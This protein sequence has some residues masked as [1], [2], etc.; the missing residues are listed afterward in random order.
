MLVSR[1]VGGALLAGSALGLTVLVPQSALATSPA[2]RYATPSGT[3]SACTTAAPCGLVTAVNDA[4]AA[5][6]VVIE[7]GSYGSAAHPLAATL[8]DNAADLKIHGQTGPHM[9]VIHSAPSGD[10]VELTRGSTLSAVKIITSAGAYGVDD[11]S[12]ASHLFVVDTAQNGTACAVYGTLSNSLCIA[13]GADGTAVGLTA[14]G[15]TRSTLDG[16]TAEAPATNGNGL[17]ATGATGPL[18]VNGTNDIAH[19]GDFAVSAIA[20]GGPV[21]I[22]LDHSD[23]NNSI[24]SGVATINYDPTNLAAPPSFV[25]A[26]AEN[27]RELSTSP[28]VNTGAADPAGETDLAGLPRTLGRAP[29]MGAYEFARRPAIQGLRV[30]KRTAHT[31]H[32]RVT[33]TPEGT[34]TKVKIAW[35]R[36]GHR[37]HSRTRSAG[38]AD[39][40]KTMRFVLHGLRRH[41]SYHLYAVAMNPGGRSTS[42]HRST[43]TR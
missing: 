21:T 38:H 18:S 30:T 5:S 32:V 4:P 33:V 9:P 1:L 41:T 29:D 24:A 23:Y 12:S 14:T 37:G 19:G 28:T 20:E 31:L 25:N 3:G 15:P 34:G 17:V 40:A 7:P 26:G 8:I 11:T 16:V 35:T 22:S 42:K 6:T 2:A 36:G 10:A 27:Y 13:T 43:R 39:T